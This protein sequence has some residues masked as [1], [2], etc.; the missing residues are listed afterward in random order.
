MKSDG[1]GVFAA[2]NESRWTWAGNLERGEAAARVQ[3][4]L[5]LAVVT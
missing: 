2:V 5:V 4:S 1:A 3:Q